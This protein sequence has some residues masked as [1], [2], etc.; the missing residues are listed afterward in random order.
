MTSAPAKFPLSTVETYAG[1]SGA[2]VRV[3]YQL[4]RCPSKRS[5]P[6][7][8][9]SVA[10]IRSAMSPVVMN[11]RSWADR[12]ASSPMAILVGEVR[13]AIRTSGSI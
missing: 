11:P 12:F 7:T 3:S 4:S 13:L 1:G 2:N 5:R 10:S 6:S 8:V 9:V